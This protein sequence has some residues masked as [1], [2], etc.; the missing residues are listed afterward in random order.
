MKEAVY[1][2]GGRDAKENCADSQTIP[3]NTAISKAAESGPTKSFVNVVSTCAILTRHP[4]GH[5]EKGPLYILQDNQKISAG[6]SGRD[7]SYNIGHNRGKC[8]G[9]ERGTGELGKHRDG[10]TDIRSLSDIPMA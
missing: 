6:F 10:H 1:S 4:L 8:T 2:T 3:L 5:V 7:R 9:M